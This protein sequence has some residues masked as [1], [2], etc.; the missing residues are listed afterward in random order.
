MG[1]VHPHE[2]LR[3]QIPVRSHKPTRHVF[4]RPVMFILPIDQ[5]EP[6]LRE[7]WFDDVNPFVST[8]DNRISFSVL[9]RRN[10]NSFEDYPK[11]TRI[12]E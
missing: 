5:N 8:L 12:A 9:G 11:R 7:W 6:T 1:S 2:I 10:A 4:H 3:F